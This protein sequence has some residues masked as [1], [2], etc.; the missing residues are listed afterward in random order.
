MTE[1]ALTVKQPWSWAIMSAGKTVENRTWCTEHRGRLWIHAG[2]N[3]DHSRPDL[4]DLAI[5]EYGGLLVRRALL[6]HVTLVNIVSDADSEWAIPGLFHWV[7][8]DPV[9]LPQPISMPG[10]QGLWVPPEE[11]TAGTH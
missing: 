7:L 2:G 4:L 9:L 10:Q 1:Y 8:T 3:V 5:A 11:A 6:G